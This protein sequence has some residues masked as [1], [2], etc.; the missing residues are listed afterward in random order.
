MA[1]FVQD[2]VAHDPLAELLGPSHVQGEPSYFAADFTI[3]GLVAAILG[4]GRGEF[5][6]VI[7]VLQ[8]V[9][10]VTQVVAQRDVGLAMFPAVE[11]VSKYK[12][13]CWSCSKRLYNLSRA[14][15]VGKAATKTFILPLSN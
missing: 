7:T 9:G 2:V 1:D 4:S 5:D 12:A 6:D 3:V 13:C 11:S 8:F 15:Q 10:H 14:Q